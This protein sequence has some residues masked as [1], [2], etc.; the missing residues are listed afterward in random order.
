MNKAKLSRVFESRV[1]DYQYT[2]SRKYHN[3]VVIMDVIGEV[4]ASADNV[5]DINDLKDAI[6]EQAN[7]AAPVFNYDLAQWF[8]NNWQAYNDIAYELGQDGMILEHARDDIMRGIE[9]AYCLTLEREAMEALNEIW[10]AAE[11][12]EEA[13][14]EKEEAEK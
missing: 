10:K 14:A 8:A 4:L 7:S 6:T 12:L 1:D 9:I 13:E 5:N 3:P 11:E 2:S